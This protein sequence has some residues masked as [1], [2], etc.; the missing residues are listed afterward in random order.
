[1]PNLVRSA[2]SCGS[3][4]HAAGGR[5]SGNDGRPRG[6]W[7]VADVSGWRFAVERGALPASKSSG[8]ARA[9]KGAGICKRTK[10]NIGSP[11]TVWM[12]TP[13]GVAH[14]GTAII[15]KVGTGMGDGIFAEE[16][17]RTG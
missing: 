15:G 4:D 1:M 3:A 9:S 16:R 12:G 17:N 10:A 11:K 7:T 2:R 8:S 13:A 14:R 5:R 6:A